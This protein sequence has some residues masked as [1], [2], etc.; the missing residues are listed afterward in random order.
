MHLS[1]IGAR[2][3]RPP[4]SGADVVRSNGTRAVE[5]TLARNDRPVRIFGLVIDDPCLP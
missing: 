3:D 5:L 1:S 4:K 2:E